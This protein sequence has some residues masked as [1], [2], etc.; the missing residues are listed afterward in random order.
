MCN[1]LYETI[2]C[3]Y[4]NDDPTLHTYMQTL[5]FKSRE[6]LIIQKIQKTSIKHEC[7]FS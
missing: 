7:A 6:K 4:L 1:K 5:F 2:N 3:A